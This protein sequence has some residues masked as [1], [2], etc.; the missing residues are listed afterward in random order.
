MKCF[1]LQLVTLWP[2]NSPSVTATGSLIKADA[3]PHQRYLSWEGVKDMTK[4]CG[5]CGSTFY[6]PKTMMDK[7]DFNAMQR[8]RVGCSKCGSAICFSCA[9]TAADARGEGGNC[10]CPN[11]DAELGRGGEAGNL[12]DHFS[13]WN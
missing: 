3:K 10:F 9:A 4:T 1:G 13:R 2:S 7:V 8:V 6:E 12:G 5:N 11:C